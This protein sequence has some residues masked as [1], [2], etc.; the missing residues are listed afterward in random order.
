MA[1]CA[2]MSAK[3]APAST[4]DAYKTQNLERTREKS[5]TQSNWFL[6]YVPKTVSVSVL[7]NSGTSVSYNN[8]E[9]S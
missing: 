3:C 8:A 6:Y 1:V 5:L 9:L 7:C 2:L 4:V